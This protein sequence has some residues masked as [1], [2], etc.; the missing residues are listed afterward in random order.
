[1]LVLLPLLLSPFSSLLA[2]G[3]ISKAAD[4]AFG[5]LKVN[6]VP[7]GLVSISP[8]PDPSTHDDPSV[9]SIHGSYRVSITD[10]SSEASSGFS[11]R[12][13]ARIWPFTDVH[14]RYVIL[15]SP[16]MTLYFCNRLAKSGRDITCL[17]GWSVITM[18]GCAWKYLRNLLAAQTSTKTSFSI[19]VLKSGKDFS[20]DLEMNLFRLASFPLRLWTSLIVRGD[21]CCNTASVL[22]VHGFIP[23]GFIMYPRNI[24]YVAPNVFFLVLTNLSVKGFIYQSLVCGASVLEAKRRTGR[25]NGE[26]WFLAGKTVKYCL[27]EYPSRISS[28]CSAIDRDTH[29]MLDGCHANISKFPFKSVHNS[30]RAF[31]DTAPPIVISWSGK[32]G[33]MATLKFSRRASAFFAG[34]LGVAAMVVTQ[35]ALG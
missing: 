17:M 1:M 6:S 14:S 12:K 26:G 3:K 13:S 29:V 27:G 24:L 19:G 31:V 35:L 11:T 34:S 25:G 18:M 10:A 9:N 33:Y 2:Y 8:A 4:Q 32:S 16:S 15:C 7:F 23:F 20:V 5:L 22:S 30:V 21:G 28:R